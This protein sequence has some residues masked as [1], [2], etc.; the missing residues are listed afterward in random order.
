MSNSIGV[1]ARRTLV[2][3]G[4]A[5][6]SG[7]SQQLMPTP[8]LIAHAKDDP[9]VGVPGA[10]Q[11]SDVDVLFVTD[12]AETVNKKNQPEF[13][14][15]R[16]RAVS[17][18]SLK[19]GIGH[20]VSWPDLVR[21][22]RT[23]SRRLPLTLSRKEIRVIG[24][25]PET[26]PKRSMVDGVV[27]DDPGYKT[28]FDES[29]ALFS[30]EIAR[31]VALNPSRHEAYVFVHGF[32]NSLDDAAFVIANLW[33]FMGRG[34]IP[35]AYSWPAGLS[36][37]YDRESGEFT[38]FHLKQFLRVLA[39][40]PELT[41]VHII[42]HSRGTD[43]TMTALRE[44]HIEYSSAGK[45]ARNELKLGNLI[46][47]AAD[48]DLDVTTQRIGAEGVFFLPER[49]TIY[50]SQSDKALG[51]AVWLFKSRVRVGDA[52]AKDLSEGQRQALLEYN[53]LQVINSRV[54][55]G[56]IGHDYFHSNPAVS[57]DIIRILRDDR[58]PGAEH[59]RPM[60][61]AADGFWEIRD[62]YMCAGKP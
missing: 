34:G 58:D 49:M 35:I 25:F 8:N 29:R 62:D 40:C 41:K 42:A 19:V 27:K 10:L 9:F 20:D 47:A 60:K 37:A 5:W 57:S 53:R 14:Y 17:F 12:R 52:S 6:V 18:G 28:S 38:V 61:R 1:I 30:K 4:L 23:Q 3:V 54:S 55:A 33:H 2:A 51:A 16:S 46:L 43:V 39:S 56:A 31:R 59:G 24:K 50:V 22:S 36:Y 32:N 48:L 13:G 44:L 26:P 21:E 15:E 45:V 7:C 11:S